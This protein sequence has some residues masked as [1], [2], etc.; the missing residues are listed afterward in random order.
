MDYNFHDTI[1]LRTPLKSVKNSFTEQDLITL[2]DSKE[3]N[4]ALFLASPDL[5]LEYSKWRGAPDFDP[6][7]KQRLIHSL[8][9]YAL[10]IH[11]RCTPFGLFAKCSLLTWQ[12]ETKIELDD[13]FRYRSTRLDMHFTCQLAQ[14]LAK[15]DVIKTYLTFYPNSSLYHLNG[16][17]RYVESIYFNEKRTYQISSVD[18]LDHI[19]HVLKKAR[20]GKT[21]EKLAEELVQYIGEV[22]LSE[23]IDFINVLIE[24]QLL[25]S[26]LEPSVSGDELLEQI[27]SVIE[28][29]NTIGKQ[30]ELQSIIDTLR[31]IQSD[32]SKLDKNLF[33]DKKHYDALENKIKSLG[34]PFNKSK[35][36]QTDFF[37]SQQVSNHLDGSV[38]PQLRRV[39]ECLNKL[40][41]EPAESNLTDFK[42]NFAERYEEAEVPLLI[43][44]D[45]EAGIGYAGN[46]NHTGDDS[47]LIQDLPIFQLGSNKR[48]IKWDSRRSF[49][50]KKLINAIK[51]GDKC[52]SIQLSE[53]NEFQSSWE[54]TPDS[55]TLMFRYFEDKIYFESLGGVSAI[56]ILGRFASGNSEINELIQDIADQEKALNE[57]K[58]IA[59]I[60][61]LPEARVGNI[62]MRP[63]FREYE[64]PY[65]SSSKLPLENQI[66]LAD[67]TISVR[68]NRLVLKSRKLGKEILPRMGNAHNFRF[69][70]VP[71]YHF[72]CDLQRNELRSRFFFTWGDIGDEFDYL[73]RVEIEGVI[74]S[75]EQWNCSKKDLEPL[76]D[77]VKDQ[78]ELVA[79]WRKKM[80]LPQHIL[81]MEGDNELPVNLDDPLSVSMFI[82]LIKKKPFIQLAEN[83][84]G[85][86]KS[87]VK[88][89]ERQSVA[90]QMVANLIRKTKVN[91]TV[92]AEKEEIYA[93]RTYAIGSEWLYYKLYCGL[94]TSDEILTEVIYPLTEDWLKR[95]IID[96]WFF[97]RYGDPHPHI[98][99]R[100][101][102]KDVRN[103]DKTIIEFH[104]A[105][106]VFVKN[107][108]IWK[109][110]TDTYQPELKRY[111]ADTIK[112]AE[113]I[114]YHDS[115]NCLQ[116]LNLLSNDNDGK[117]IRWLY[118]IKAVDELLNNFGFSLEEKNELIER[119]RNAF[120]REFGMNKR[121]NKQL[122]K[123]YRVSKKEIVEILDGKWEQDDELSQLIELLQSKSAGIIPVAE[124]IKMNLSG[125]EP[126]KTLSDFIASYSHMF[127]NRFFKSRQRLYELVVYD[128]LS[129][130]YRSQIIRI[131]MK[132]QE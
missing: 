131:K 90:N 11:S 68:Q 52:V 24:E 21:I 112:L 46:N 28:K 6:V 130:T 53:L 2:F 63:S 56:N 125:N 84:L 87:S 105:I 120:G 72:L 12:K 92:S 45:N 100:F 47:P 107:E 66:E 14:E 36:Y 111:G 76:L 75:L 74:V 19:T 17:I 91:T 42:E 132:N 96:Q 86:E 117:K 85:K 62:L 108:L 70:S 101:H 94:K 127:I 3:G 44:L 20:S 33:N 80:R 109:V 16:K 58:I 15:L 106:A 64:I 71:V 29:I 7:K 55:M 27:L 57:D 61:H 113:Q 97:I 35:L 116:V 34:I 129:R 88:N 50:F 1:I 82:D 8:L 54:N 23:A 123:K 40:T 38:R 51:S 115:R 65:L 104:E 25:I 102:F 5:H 118:A 60:V 67:L 119:L 9:K 41:G 31:E 89:T 114:F 30:P 26:E 98:R 122:D 95:G 121:L 77:K 110:V 93:K 43:A 37:S 49:L 81:L 99:V 79:E 22:T 59:E 18:D 13:Q 126:E 4:E 69:N 48:E 128:F 78:N 39:A 73:P 83:L 32:L 103:F 124:K 10:R